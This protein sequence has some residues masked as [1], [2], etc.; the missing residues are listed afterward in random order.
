MLTGSCRY[1]GR[2]CEVP[3][4]GIARLRRLQRAQPPLRLPPGIRLLT[5]TQRSGMLLG[6]MGTVHFSVRAPRTQNVLSLTL[7][8]TLH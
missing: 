2:C 4:E 7:V 5:P 1:P 3:S 8:Q 6:Q